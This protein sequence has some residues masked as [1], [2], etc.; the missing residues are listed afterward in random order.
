MDLEPPGLSAWLSPLGCCRR[1]DLSLW[2]GHGKGHRQT[3]TGL[4]AAFWSIVDYL[5]AKAGPGQA[6][7]HYCLLHSCPHHLQF[8]GWKCLV[9]SGRTDGY[10]K[11][12]PS[13]FSPAASLFSDGEEGSDC[14]Q[15]CLGGCLHQPHLGP[16]LFL[17][18]FD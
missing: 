16:G 12:G 4:R 2:Q 18:S 8:F 17:P 11:L 14:R 6:H 9:F 3:R 15:T 7:S 5:P 13:R 10:P 1:H